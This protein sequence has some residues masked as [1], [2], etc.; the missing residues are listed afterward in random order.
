MLAT[1]VAGC[2]DYLWAESI[3]QGSIIQKQQLV[4]VWKLV[5]YEMQLMDTGERQRPLG[6]K[7]I[8]YLIFTDR[9]VMLMQ[10]SAQRKPTGT[11]P[12]LVFTGPYRIDGSKWITQVDAGFQPWI[13]AEQTREFK[14]VEGRLH[15][16]APLFPA[17]LMNP[18]LPKDRMARPTVVYERE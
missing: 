4:G 10:E 7:P 6:D 15:F 16:T 17:Y 12:I 18:T 9:R 11:V 5:S 1:E 3:I 2:D 13:G 14:F 8:G